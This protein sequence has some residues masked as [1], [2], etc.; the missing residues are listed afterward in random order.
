M[1][2]KT[3]RQLQEEGNA[4]IFTEMTILKMEE[5]A[6]EMKRKSQ[7]RWLVFYTFILIV[8]TPY[9]LKNS[10]NLKNTMLNYSLASFL[11]VSAIIV[12]T[13]M[14]NMRVYVPAFAVGMGV[15]VEAEVLRQRTRMF[16]NIIAPSIGYVI[17]MVLLSI[18]LLL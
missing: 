17:T 6:R 16:E 1:R 7:I 2:A 18:Y 11:S 10:D 15:G 9:I 13:V 3:F 14:G 4:E 12:F 8:A 5:K